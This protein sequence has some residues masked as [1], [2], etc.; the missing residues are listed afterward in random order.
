M[1]PVAF[2]IQH[3]LVSGDLL[4]EFCHKL[5]HLHRSQN[6]LTD[7]LNEDPGD[8]VIKDSLKEN[9]M[10]IRILCRKI[11]ILQQDLPESD[12]RKILNLCA[13]DVAPPAAHA[14]QTSI[15]SN[16]KEEDIKS[17]GLYL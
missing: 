3:E 5:K 15:S 10:S 2:P 17:D 1:D 11:E 4:D 13:T 14:N 8:S 12:P 7:Y 9:E 16:T 6:E